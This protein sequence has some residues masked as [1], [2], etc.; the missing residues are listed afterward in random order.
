[1][2]DQ[3]LKTPGADVLFFRKKLRKT[4]WEAVK[5]PRYNIH[6]FVVT[7][8]LPNLY[9]YMRNFICNLIDLEQWYLSLI[10]NTCMG[11]LQTFCG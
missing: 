11:K 2:N 9:Y 10:W 8:I 1:M 3:L 7:L 4:L 6:C 5:N